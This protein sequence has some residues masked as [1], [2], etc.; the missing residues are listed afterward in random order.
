MKKRTVIA[1]RFGN[2]YVIAADDVSWRFKG[3]RLTCGGLESVVARSGW[4][5][6]HDRHTSVT[7]LRIPFWEGLRIKLGVN[8]IQHTI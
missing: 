4:Y 1:D 7:I 3:A 6:G 8:R 2:L 5:Y